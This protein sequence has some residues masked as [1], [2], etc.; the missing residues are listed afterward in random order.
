[1]DRSE[2]D[3]IEGALDRMNREEIRN[4]RVL[5]ERA[6]SEEKDQIDKG[7]KKFTGIFLKL[8]GSFVQG[9]VS[10]RIQTGS[11][12]KVVTVHGE[13]PNPPQEKS[14]ELQR[15]LS[16]RVRRQT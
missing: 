12:G 9:V 14:Q 2:S 1:M 13:R 7:E 8:M 4:H 10:W 6:R 15:K 3:W 11:A 16:L 5:R